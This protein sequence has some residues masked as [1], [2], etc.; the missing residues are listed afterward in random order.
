MTPRPKRPKLPVALDEAG[1]GRHPDDFKV[2][3]LE[4]FHGMFPD[5]TD[6]EL[7]YNPTYAKRF[8]RAV[9]TEC[10]ADVREDVIL[11][12]LVN[13]RKSGFGIDHTT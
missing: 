13:C 7:L 5:W 11:A 9:R 2:I 12:T 10:G 8:V 1:F 3:V 4:V 6:E